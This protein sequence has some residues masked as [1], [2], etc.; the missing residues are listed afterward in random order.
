MR[1]FN[2]LLTTNNNSGPFDIYYTSEGNN[3]IAPLI[4]GSYATNISA[5]QLASGVNILADY[6]VSNIYVINNKETCRSIQNLPQTPKLNPYSCVTWLATNN[7]TNTATVTYIDCNGNTQ[8]GTIPPGG[9]GSFSTNGPPPTCISNCD[10]LSFRPDPQYC[11][12]YTIYNPCTSVAIDIKYIDCS[13]TSRVINVGAGATIILQALSNTIYGYG[14]DCGTKFTKNEIPD[15]YNPD[16]NASC[17]NFIAINK[18]SLPAIISYTDCDGNVS[19]LDIPAGGY[20]PYSSL[21]S[22][23]KCHSGD[24]NCLQVY[25]PTQT[26]GFDFKILGSYTPEVPPPPIPKYTL[27]PKTTFVSGKGFTMNEGEEITIEVTTEN[28]NAGTTLYWGIFFYTGIVDDLDT[29]TEGNISTGTVTINNNKASFKIKAKADNLTEPNGDQIIFARLYPSSGRVY[30]E[31]LAESKGISIIDTSKSPTVLKV[32]GVRAY[33]TNIYRYEYTKNYQA[34]PPAFLSSNNYVV[35]DVLGLYE[36]PLY[37]RDYHQYSFIKNGVPIDKKPMASLPIA[38][39]SFQY[40]TDFPWR[41]SI[42]VTSSDGSQIRYD[43]EK[44]FTDNRA[45][46]VYPL[47]ANVLTFENTTYKNTNSSTYYTDAFVSDVPTVISPWIKG[48]YN[49][50]SYAYL[51]PRTSTYALTGSISFSF[52]GNDT[53]GNGPFETDQIGPSVF[54]IFGVIE[55]STTPKNASS[56]T[57]IAYT[58]MSKLPDNI[59]QQNKRAN[60]AYNQQESLIW[61]DNDMQNQITFQLSAQTDAVISAGNYV[62]FTLYWQDIN[63]VFFTYDKNYDA[64]GANDLK[65]TIGSAAN[66]SIFS[67][68]DKT[69]RS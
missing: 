54:R 38:R 23:Y 22:N 32:C 50:G 19:T 42:Y 34:I 9:T 45:E 1:K 60:F 20:V 47:N 12:Y 3:I 37:P 62:R 14:G 53:R 2:V 10:G 55:K 68:I 67:I 13:G 4:G 28:V 65:F 8:T 21:S 58:E 61:F 16:P 24:C 40:A 51:V 41:S 49:E 7:S 59:I 46:F 52:R 48:A 56:W 43:E 17:K 35:R 63:G 30:E 33:D 64:S 44:T 26:C 66:P 11:R 25:T 18:C 31:L 5:S 36:Y 27:T 6:G 15:P 57:K 39:S 69:L 29:T